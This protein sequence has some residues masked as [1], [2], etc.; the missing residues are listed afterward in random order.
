M[1]NCLK[2]PAHSSRQYK[3]WLSHVLACSFC[4]LGLHKVVRSGRKI[5]ELFAA[6]SQRFQK[7]SRTAGDL[8]LD[9][10]K[11]TIDDEALSNL[12]A[13]LKEANVEAY[14]NPITPR[15]A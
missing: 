2:N 6:D 3:H 11:N 7:F 15:R 8:T 10:S 9:F 14:A 12:L 13:L 1:D 5:K 4:H